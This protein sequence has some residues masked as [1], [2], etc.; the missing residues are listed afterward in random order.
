MA[1]EKRSQAAGK[2]MHGGGYSKNRSRFSNKR[3]SGRGT[4]KENIH[5]SKFIKEA[6]PQTQKD[7]QA[8]NSFDDFNVL[9]ILAR[10]IRARRFKS[11]SPIQDQAVPIGLQGKD[12]IGIA[13]TGTGKTVAFS[14]PVINRLLKEKDAKVIIMAPTRELASQILDE[15]KTLARGARIFWCLL[16]GGS[17]MRM[18]LRD[19]QK[20]PRIIIGTP[21]RIKDHIERGSLD[22]SN[23]NMVVLDEV[24]RMLDMGFV[25]DMRRILGKITTKKQSFFFSATMD[26]KISTLINEF[27][28]DP[29]SVTVK[30]GDTSDNVDQNIVEYATREEK[31]QKLE[32]ILKVNEENKTL[33]FDETKR[34]VERL[35]RTLTEKGFRT[36]AIHGDKSQGQRQRALTNFKRSKAR[37]MIAT[38]VAARGIDVADITHVINYATPQ[39]YSDYVHRIGRAGRAGKAGYALTFIPIGEAKALNQTKKRAPQKVSHKRSNMRRH[40]KKPAQARQR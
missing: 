10:N 34:G 28:H 17:P 5:P 29:V 7:Y 37:I 31:I 24:D 33:I 26:Q 22:L 16:I 18:Q 2:R 9:P 12:I 15:V 13:N 19:L 25:N 14:I 3:S 20:N 32:E 35:A 36:E 38:D 11:P 27:A 6:K 40:T 8:Q 30:T 21:G 23:V 39:S 1:Y 4:K